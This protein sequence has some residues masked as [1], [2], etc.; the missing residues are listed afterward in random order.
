MMT[1]RDNQNVPRGIGLDR[2][3]TLN[4]LLLE[5]CENLVREK[6]MRSPC[7]AI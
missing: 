7:V 3:G 4:S 5:V 2:G 1:S 6:A